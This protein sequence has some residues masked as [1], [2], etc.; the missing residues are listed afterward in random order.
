MINKDSLTILLL[1]FDRLIEDYNYQ[2]EE[3]INEEQEEK[4]LKAIKKRI[5]EETTIEEEREI[6]KKLFEKY[7]KKLK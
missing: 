1:I 6:F 2:K 5:G 4:I 3:L 7:L